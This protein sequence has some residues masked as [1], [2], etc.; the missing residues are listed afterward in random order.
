[1]DRFI[2]NYLLNDYRYFEQQLI[3]YNNMSIRGNYTKD[4]LRILSYCQLSCYSIKEYIHFLRVESLKDY[5]L[6]YEGFRIR[7]K[8][9]PRQ[10][11]QGFWPNFYTIMKIIVKGEENLG[12]Q[13]KIVNLKFAPT[14]DT[15]YLREGYLTVEKC[16]RTKP[17]IYEIKINEKGQ[18]V[19]PYIWIEE[20]FSFNPDQPLEAD[21]D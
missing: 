8:Q 3:K 2:K 17:K 16:K 13:E 18:K 11:G 4:Q 14:V 9:Q 20:I 6:N 7:G 15:S 5:K 21:D 19:Y 1:M 12:P 10:D